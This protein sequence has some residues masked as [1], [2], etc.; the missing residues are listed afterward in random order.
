MRR[1]RTLLALLVVLLPR[2]ASAKPSCGQGGATGQSTATAGGGQ[3]KLSVPSSYSPAQ[4]IPLLLALHGDEGTP[5]YIYSVFLGLQ[6]TSAGAFILVAPKAKA[7]GGSWYQATSEHVTFVNAVLS[8]VLATYNIDQ[9]RIWI[10]GWS[11]G[12]TFLGY[13]A[14]LRQDVLAAVVYHMGGGGGGSY[15]PPAGSCKIPARFVIGSADFLY[16]LA[17]TQYNTLTGKGHETVWIELPGV[18]HTFDPATL[19]ETWAWL[20]KKT[21]CGTT[22][23]GS[24]G[25]KPADAGP[26]PPRDAGAPTPEGGKP[27]VEASAPPFGTDA[28][29]IDRDGRFAGPGEERDGLG[30]GC[31]L[32]PASPGSAWLLLLVLLGLRR[33][34]R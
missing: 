2:G 13:Y 15:A 24:C 23:P 18:A 22:T 26:P 6:K 32:A 9:D 16:N 14:V 17:K 29:V 7:G 28:L 30:G 10:T 19:P 34:E 20:Q 3:F 12:A 27:G 5:D 31:S 4:P 21:L 8:S 11:G 1:A 25:P 33:R